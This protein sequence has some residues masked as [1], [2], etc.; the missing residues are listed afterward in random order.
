MSPHTIPTRVRVVCSLNRSAP[1]LDRLSLIERLRAVATSAARA[2]QPVPLFFGSSLV[3]VVTKEL[4]T[5]T[6]VTFF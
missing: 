1:P 6:I 3:S 5:R 2:L 4:C